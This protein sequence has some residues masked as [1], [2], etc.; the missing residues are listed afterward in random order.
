[1]KNT[2]E[3]PTKLK[4]KWSEEERETI[5]EALKTS[6]EWLTAH[7]DADKEEYETYL[8]ELEGICNPII[9]RLYQQNGGQQEQP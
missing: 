5:K 1:M 2:I 6:D 3:D 9:S 7:A 4:D 8:K